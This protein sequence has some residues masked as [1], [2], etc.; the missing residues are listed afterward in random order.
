MIFRRWL[1]IILILLSPTVVAKT[2]W[3]YDLVEDPPYYFPLVKKS[4]IPKRFHKTQVDYPCRYKPGTVIVDKSDRYLYFIEQ[5]CRALRY[6]IAVGKEG[7]KW[8]GTATVGRKTKW[9]GWTPTVNMRRQKKHLPHYMPGGPMNPLG[10]RALY[11]YRNGRDTL[12][13]IHGT[14]EP[15]SI[16]RAVSFG[17]IRMLN[18]HIY[19]L[20]DRVPIGATVIVKE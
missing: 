16:G 1:L 11:L 9:P 15:G 5:K 8:A 13:R 12:Y 18:E 2:N 6:G 14:N 10:A 3:Y 20:Y 7:V 19:D 4:K 17:C